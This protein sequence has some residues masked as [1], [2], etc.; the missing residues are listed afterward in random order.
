MR[1][2]LGRS[3]LCLALRSDLGRAGSEERGQAK[4]PVS[5][6]GACVLR[7][8]VVR[9]QLTPFSLLYRKR[10]QGSSTRI[11]NDFRTT[12]GRGSDFPKSFTLCSE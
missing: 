7:S 4:P 3:A 2:S 6:G 11:S 8:P 10:T 1:N 9:T 12:G 5:P